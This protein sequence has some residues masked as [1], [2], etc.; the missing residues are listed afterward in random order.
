MSRDRSVR[1]YRAA[2]DA[3]DE[4][5]SAATR[6]AI[7]AA[8]ARQVQAGPRDAREPI[9][10]PRIAPRKR[11]PYAAAA[12][13][14][15]SSLA[16]MMA[17]RTEREMPT[18]TAPVERTAESAA[19]SSPV[20]SSEPPPP[21]AAPTA[22]QEIAS[23]PATVTAR[24]DKQAKADSS[25]AGAAVAAG[26]AKVALPAEAARSKEEVV[27][28]RDV[29][30]RAA[31]PAPATAPTPAAAPPPPAAGDAAPASMPAQLAKRQAAPASE[32]TERRRNESADMASAERSALQ[33]A[34]AAPPAAG[35][36]AATG[37]LR[38]EADASKATSASEWLER[39]I[40]LRRAG[41]HDEA[42]IELKRFRES[43]PQVTVPAEALP[44]TGTR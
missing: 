36:G 13:V 28:L 20:P 21:T 4:R 34:P 39:I 3:L 15:L 16:V 19:P 33:Q 18:F 35:L 22:S 30:S 14:L 31:A 37:A 29:P 5:P 27:V 17:T 42:D 24:A 6:A 41:R 9:A 2:T 26:E 32:A 7:L 40:K 1:G 25:R 11:W 23:A 8:A 43:Y 12:A 44:A 10:V 38:T